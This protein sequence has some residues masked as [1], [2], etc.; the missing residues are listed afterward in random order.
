MFDGFTERHIDIGD[1][2]IFVRTKGEGAPLLLLHG[3]PETHVMWHGI[4]PRLAESFTVV[5]ADLPGYGKSAGPRVADDHVPHSKR[6]FANSLV[7]AMSRLG[8]SRFMV[9]GHDRGGRVAYRM[10]LD[11]ADRV[12]KLAV[13]DVVPTGVV[14]DR[15][16]ARL[17]T[18]FW[19]WA[20][21]SQPPPLPE[22]LLIADPEA[23][24]ED[25]ISA[26]G[27]PAAAF[28]TEVI[29]A[30]VDA[31]RNVAS[32]T[33]ICEEYRATIAVDADVDCEDLRAGRRIAC[34]LLVL[35]SD[36]AVNDWYAA[37]GGPLG[38]W[39]QWAL[40][41]RGRHVPGGHFFPEANPDDTGRL[42]NDF[43]A[44][45]GPAFA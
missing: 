10:A 39:R 26:W 12:A 11:H 36:G 23:V 1:G 3:F 29:T 14:L 6:A 2:S 34:P 42:L 35:G 30:Y 43:F 24:V 32:A 17:A 8:F 25:A 21:L 31:L 15:A 28:P 41:V 19:P 37:D 22:R 13:L 33:A 38:V 16:D 45:T 20:L 5:C 4:A 40:D 7:A 27:S 44:T 18:S 9:A